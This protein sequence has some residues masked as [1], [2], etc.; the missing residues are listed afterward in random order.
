MSMLG[1]ALLLVAGM[2]AGLLATYIADAIYKYARN[3]GKNGV[4]AMRKNK[5]KDAEA[6]LQ[7]I[8]NER[9]RVWMELEKKEKEKR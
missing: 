8:V 9:N 5:K 3:H 4:Q 2:L 6:E 1:P 7:R